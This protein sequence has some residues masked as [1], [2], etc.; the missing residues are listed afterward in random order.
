MFLGIVGSEIRQHSIKS[1][2]IKDIEYV[3]AKEHPDISKYGLD[4][5]TNPKVVYNTLGVYA[6][7]C[8]IPFDTPVNSEHADEWREYGE[9]VAAL[10]K[11]CG[12][13]FSHVGSERN[14]ITNCQD[15]RGQLGD[16]NLISLGTYRSYLPHILI[17]LT[18]PYCFGGYISEAQVTRKYHRNDEKIRPRLHSHNGR[19]CSNVNRRE[20]RTEKG[21][22]EYMQY[23][24]GHRGWFL[25]F[26]K[27]AKLHT[28]LQ[29]FT[30]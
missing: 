23:C 15:P 26:D 16:V 27:M 19:K 5:L 14:W 30:Q 3:F 2:L 6:E 20:A 18:V 12:R 8:S 1:G 11:E 22:C 9:C 28:L 7:S 10:V 4:I 21:S 17:I 13:A 24:N 29:R 25:G